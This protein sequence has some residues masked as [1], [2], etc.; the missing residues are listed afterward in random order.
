MIPENLCENSP[1]YSGREDSPIHDFLEHLRIERHLSPHTIHAYQRDLTRVEH[2]LTQGWENLDAAALR[3]IT[4]RLSREG[5]HPHSI[6]R[7]LSAVRSFARWA[8]REGR[9]SHNLTTG[10]RGPKAHRTLPG[11][12]T[13]EDTFQALAILGESEIDQR[14]Q[15]IL[16]L[17]YS[18][19]LRL[20]EL[21]GLNLSDLD[22]GS[23]QVRV[24]GKGRKERIVPV[25]RKA[26]Q[27]LQLWIQ[28][29]TQ[30]A[31]PEETALFVSRRGTRLGARSIQQRLHQAGL[32]AGINERLHPHRLRHAFAS[33][34]LESS[35][36]L[37]AVQELLGHA[38]L[39]TTQI[40][41]HLDFQHLAQVYDQTHPRA[42]RRNAKTS[43]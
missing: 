41:T 18:S 36:D 25:G 31:L 5:L 4:A 7:L 37:R 27:A 6:R 9:L 26:R 2:L 8:L 29:R 32:R 40:Y 19:G 28:L 38:D 12:L 35:G 39:A 43:D 14:D 21:V 22:L 33:H 23:A 20:S 13:V 10:V 11:T 30:W 34:L 17:L 3:S 1:S 16:E 15:A 42:R 24:L